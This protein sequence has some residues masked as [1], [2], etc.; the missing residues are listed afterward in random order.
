MSKPLTT[1]ERRQMI[2]RLL[3]EKPGV[4]V[5]DLA[6]ML[7]VS[8]GTIRND[9]AA[10]DEEEQ[11]TRVR[12]GA[13]ARVANT[14]SNQVLSARER[15]NSDAKRWIAQWAASM[16]EDGDTIILDASTTVLHMV[17]FLK[18]RRDLTV[19][20]NGVEIARRLAGIQ[21]NHVILLGGSLRRD[22]N[23]ITGLLGTEILRNL[24]AHTAFVSCAGFS[25][26]TG[27]LETDIEQAQIKSQ[28]IKATRRVVALVD[29]TK[30]DQIALTS[31]APLSA[32][33]VLVTDINVQ[34]EML[35][36][37]EQANVAVTVCSDHTT[38]VH[39]PHQGN[40]PRYKIGFANLSE[41]MLFGRAV[42]RGLERAA[43]NNDQ[44]ELLIADNQL[45]GE[46]ALE[47]ADSM[48]AQGIDLMIEYQIEETIGTQLM[49]KFNRANI[50]VIAVDIPLVGATYFGV[51]NY[52]TG[53]IAGEALGQAVQHEWL[54]Q[55]D[56]LIVLEHPRAG[57]LPA[58]RIQG[59][60]DG[61]FAARGSLEPEKIL[62]LDCG[63]TSDIAAHEVRSVLQRIP[64]GSHIAIISFNDDA[65][66]GALEAAR[67]AYR[68]EEFLIVGQGA[69]SRLRDEL[70]RGDSRIVGST[71]FYPEQ[72]GE[73]LLEIAH[74]LM[75]GE[76]VSP[77]VYVEHV[78]ISADNV[79]QLYPQE[80]T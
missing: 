28:M 61:F 23:A 4:K 52:K 74:R 75:N 36:L 6:E 67:M 72:Y 70:R 73:R 40:P 20:T 57:A 8:A 76:P 35:E 29:H 14:S 44:F 2:V 18:S 60:L 68:A 21:Y 1:Y 53:Y 16:I 38:T 58:A 27:L 71:A 66:L 43:K 13:V 41:N 62:V 32:V 22:G 30:F 77:A 12:G 24:H 45:S 9:L 31:F 78:F 39:T 34:P 80:P 63:N 50:P 26:E 7:D 56:Y 65:A 42:R 10:L 33:D 47:V 3:Q 25:A 11:I 5:T 59:Q 69:D 15:V 48:I 55:T 17:S 64:Q 19:I 49:Y 79:D 51:D 37:L 54:G 46:I